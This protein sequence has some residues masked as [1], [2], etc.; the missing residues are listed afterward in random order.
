MRSDFGFFKPP[1]N[2]H[3]EFEAL[4]RSVYKFKLFFNQLSID[5]QRELVMLRNYFLT[6]ETLGAYSEER[7]RKIESI[8][9]QIAY[10]DLQKRNP[11]MSPVEAIAKARYGTI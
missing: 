3:E 4:F 9:I 5:H 1:L 10:I 11:A 6:G 8:L 7:L 2:Y